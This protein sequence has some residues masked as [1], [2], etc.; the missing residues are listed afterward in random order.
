MEQKYLYETHLHTAEVSKC[1]RSTAEEQVKLYKSLGYAG[2]CVTDHYLNGNTSVPRDIQWSERVDL[3]VR[4]YENAKEAG[5]KYGIDVFFGFEYT[6]PNGNDFLIY[7]LD[8]QWILDNPDQLS[9]DP[10]SYFRKVRE[11][12]G[13]VIHAHP[14]R[15]AG[16]IDM[17]RLLPREVDGVEAIN[18]NRTD[19]ENKLAAQY[20]E[21]YGLPCSA[22]SDNHAGHQKRLAGIASDKKFDSVKELILSVLNGESQIFTK[23]MEQ[24]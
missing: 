5:E 1:A 11:D 17:I 9:L 20:A 13:I 16:Y 6:I 12:G 7:G 23:D 22:G 4:G 15:E 10:R 2:I 18:A 14:F 8:K 24:Q 19:F 21:N 3:F